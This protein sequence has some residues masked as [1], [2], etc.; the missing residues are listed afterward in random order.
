MKTMEIAKK[1]VELNRQGKG[2][3]TLKTLFS[4]DMVSVEAGAMPGMDREAKGKAAVLKKGEWWFSNHDIHSFETL[5]PWPHDERFIVLYKIDVTHKPS[6]Q[7]IKMEEAGLYTV[8]D[9]K[10]VR[11]EFFYDMAG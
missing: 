7:R 8:R 10:I 3:E 6:G 4:D 2:E 1:M 11:E 5:G 9:G